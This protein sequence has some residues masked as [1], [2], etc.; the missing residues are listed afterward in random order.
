M[1]LSGQITD[2]RPIRKNSLLVIAIHCNISKATVL[3]QLKL[4]FCDFQSL[5]PI[6][7]TKRLFVHILKQDLQGSSLNYRLHKLQQGHVTRKNFQIRLSEVFPFKSHKLILRRKVTS[8][9]YSVNNM[10]HFTTKMLKFGFKSI[11]CTTPPSP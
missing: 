8:G 7:A 10:K 11:L 5:L 6:K 9:L 4:F 1:R 3:H 2:H